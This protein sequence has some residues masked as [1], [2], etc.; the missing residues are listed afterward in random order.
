MK[1]QLFLSVLMLALASGVSLLLFL[2][3]P[4]TDIEEPAELTVSVDVARVVKQD[5]RIQVQ[6]Q[7]TVT[8]LKETAILAEVKGRIVDVADSFNEMIDTFNK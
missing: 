5:L 1:K 7:G 4:P 8:P 3:R 2:T 6:A